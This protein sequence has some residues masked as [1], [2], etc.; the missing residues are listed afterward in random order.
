MCFNCFYKKQ[1]SLYDFFFFGNIYLNKNEFQ[2]KR[3]EELSGVSP[4][5]T[6]SAQ[7]LQEYQGFTYLLV[8]TFNST[9]HFY[10]QSPKFNFE[11]YCGRAGEF[12]WN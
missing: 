9:A 4:L 5:D 11:I 7:N 6:R 3:R 1:Y 2:A 8:S 12:S 10:F